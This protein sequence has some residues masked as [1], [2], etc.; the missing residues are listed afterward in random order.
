MKNNVFILRT[1]S[2]LSEPELELKLGVEGDIRVKSNIEKAIKDQTP[3]KKGIIK[4]NINAAL[5]VKQN[6]FVIVTRKS[7]HKILEVCRVVQSYYY[8]EKHTIEVE[9][10][11]QVSRDRLSLNLKNVLRKPRILYPIIS[12]DSEEFFR[13]INASSLDTTTN[14]SNVHKDNIT[15]SSFEVEFP[16]NNSKSAAKLIIPND[17][18][19]EDLKSTL[20]KVNN[21]LSSML[22]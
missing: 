3:T 2:E 10:M 17:A 14:K 9:V 22:D 5:S 11:H 12:E 15:K 7:F 1:N 6:D 21:F 8:N 18:S 16:I 13:I 20:I 4:N 19:P